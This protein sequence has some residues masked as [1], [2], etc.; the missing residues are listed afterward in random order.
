MT[1]PRVDLSFVAALLLAAGSLPL[2]AQASVDPDD[3]LLGVWRLDLAA[4]RYSPGPAV[5]TE[6]RTYT[7]D[8]QGILGVIERVHADARTERIEY[9]P[10]TDQQVPVSGA[11][12]YD[13][14]RLKR[15][16]S[17]TAEGI[18]SHAG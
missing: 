16:D 6:T 3:V 7:R 13:A 10:E 14:I 9:R 18:L 8:S 2:L 1:S 11:R 5:R 12:S 4:S 15:V 17:R